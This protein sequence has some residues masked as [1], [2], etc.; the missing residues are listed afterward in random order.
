LR[1]ERRLRVFANW[2]VRR[3]FGPRKEEVTG[4]WRKLHN[5]EV[6]DLY[7]SP[8]IL[9]VI[10]RRI[11]RWVGHVALMGE[12]RDVNRVLLRKPEGRDHLGDRG[13]DGRIILGWIF[14]Q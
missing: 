14:R 4:E 2:V 12:R 5:K 10:K 1:Q 9:R 3:I 7:S 8:N 6:N 11:M 13:S